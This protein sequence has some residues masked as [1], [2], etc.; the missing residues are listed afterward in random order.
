[1]VNDEVS[2]IDLFAALEKTLREL[3]KLTCEILVDE[4]SVLKTF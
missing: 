3:K 4:V 2:E 1:M